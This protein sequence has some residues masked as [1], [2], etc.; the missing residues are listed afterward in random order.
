MSPHAVNDI[1]PPSPLLRPV[2][3][4][5]TWRTASTFL[6]AQFRKDSRNRCF[7]E[8]LHEFMASLG[9]DNVGAFNSDSMAGLMRHPVLDRPYFD[10]Y[11]LVVDPRTNRIPNTCDQQAVHRFFGM[12]LECTNLYLESLLA[13]A[14]SEGRRPVLQ[15]CRTYGRLAWLTSHFDARH[16]FSFRDPRDQWASCYSFNFDYFLPLFCAIAAQRP[17]A[18]RRLLDC[19]LSRPLPRATHFTGLLRDSTIHKLLSRACKFA[20]TLSASDLY[21]VF[22]SE[23][24]FALAAGRSYCD[25]VVDMNRLSEDSSYRE[26]IAESWQTPLDGCRVPR[27]ERRPLSN[28]ELADIE[29]ETKLA[30]G[31]APMER[32]RAC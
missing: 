27:Y 6:F 22:Y 31:L 15:F 20:R 1:A 5:C 19:R 8:P 23:W 26:R 29:A 13:A 28:S 17:A 30:F 11:R 18:H 12:P 7:Q 32:A 14:R 16:V 10:E 24:L 21:R 2:F 3:L 25:E 9:L 4:H